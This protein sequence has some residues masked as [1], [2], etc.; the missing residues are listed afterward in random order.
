MF[1]SVAWCRQIEN[2]LVSMRQFENCK[3]IT[4]PNTRR[5]SHSTGK[6]VI[7]SKKLISRRCHLNLHLSKMFAA[8]QNEIKKKKSYKLSIFDFRN[9]A[10]MEVFAIGLSYSTL[11]YSMDNRISDVNKSDGDFI[12]C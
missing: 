3:K 7:E 1:I 11:V 8:S 5:N 2:N 4:I 10:G 9:K 6:Q 12:L